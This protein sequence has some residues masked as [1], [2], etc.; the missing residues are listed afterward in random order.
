M[1]V[2]THLQTQTV[3]PAETLQQ[4]FPPD[5][6]TLQSL[7]YIQRILRFTE[8]RTSNFNPDGEFKEEFFIKAERYLG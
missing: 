5:D 6:P 4:L 3:S 1:L 2:Q 7:L 8:N